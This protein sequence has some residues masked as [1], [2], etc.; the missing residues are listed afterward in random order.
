[1]KCGL[2]W[3]LRQVLEKWCQWRV[4]YERKYEANNDEQ[5][6]KA[7]SLKGPLPHSKLAHKRA[8]A[9]IS[10]KDLWGKSIRI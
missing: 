2:E 10:C 7:Q 3:E 6:L 5:S 8:H 4:I 1:M 9:R